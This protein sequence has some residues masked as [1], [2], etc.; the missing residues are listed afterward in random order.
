MIGYYYLLLLPYVCWLALTYVGI[1]VKEA[2]VG[3]LGTVKYQTEAS[4]NAP[5][6]SGLRKDDM[7]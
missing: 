5:M 6:A 7:E 4:G 1:V 3:S 2:V